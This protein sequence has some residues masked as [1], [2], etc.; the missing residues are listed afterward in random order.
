MGRNRNWIIKKLKYYEDNLKKAREV[1]NWNAIKDKEFSVDI[2]DQD[3]M[4]VTQGDV[5]DVSKL[6]LQCRDGVVVKV[7]NTEYIFLIALVLISR[8]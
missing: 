1:A 3:L 6:P 8:K 5:N 2:L 4:R 7:S